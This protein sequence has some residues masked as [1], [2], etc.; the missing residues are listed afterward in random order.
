VHLSSGDLSRSN[1]PPLIGAVPKR[2]GEQS[3]WPRGVPSHKQGKITASVT[4]ARLL[5][6]EGHQR[7]K[8]RV[9]F[10]RVYRTSVY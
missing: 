2:A 5:A 8:T 9:C 4:G 7:A 6:S 1:Y 3:G 10:P